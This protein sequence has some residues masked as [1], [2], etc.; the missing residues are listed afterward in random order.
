M[1]ASDKPAPA[2]AWHVRLDNRASGQH[3]VEQFEAALP[4]EPKRAIAPRLAESLSTNFEKATRE[5]V[6]FIYPNGVLVEF[7][8]TWF[9]GGIA[10]NLQHT[11]ISHNL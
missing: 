1:R 4:V 6:D 2:R 9:N 11:D 10:R 3:A 7:L 8:Y 5:T